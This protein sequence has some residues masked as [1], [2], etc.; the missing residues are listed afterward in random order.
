LGG[1]LNCFFFLSPGKCVLHTVH[2]SG[3]AGDAD[4]GHGN[5]CEYH[6]DP[7]YNGALYRCRKDAN[8]KKFTPIRKELGKEAFTR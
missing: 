5:V 1:S 7:G 6:I 2:V 8:V 4:G 3:V